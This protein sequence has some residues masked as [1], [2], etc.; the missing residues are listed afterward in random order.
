MKNNKNQTQNHKKSKLAKYREADIKHTKRYHSTERKFLKA[1]NKI[2]KTNKREIVTVRELCRTAGVH[3]STF[4]CH[5]RNLFDFS[6]RQDAKVLRHFSEIHDTLNSSSGTPLIFYTRLASFLYQHRLI[7][8]TRLGRYEDRLLRE[9]FF[10]LRP[11]IILSWSSYGKTTDLFIYNVF[12]AEAVEIVRISL[13]S[14]GTRNKQIEVLARQLA[15]LSISAPR[16]LAPL[17]KIC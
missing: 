11:T 2:V 6:R 5:F 8:L 16:S 14:S 3:A 1:A 4:Y 17:I 13:R 10:K 15:R 12:T 9:I 7:L